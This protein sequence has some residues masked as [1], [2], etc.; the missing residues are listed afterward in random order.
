MPN[1]S[2]EFVTLDL[3]PGRSWKSLV[4]TIKENLKGSE[5][6]LVKF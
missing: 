1:K 4:E 2:Q 5:K 6:N 3:R